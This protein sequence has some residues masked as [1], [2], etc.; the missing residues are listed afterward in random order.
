[1]MYI[2]GLFIL[3][4]SVLT[5]ID[6]ASK[7]AD[8]KLRVG[9]LV[10]DDVYLLDF[11]GPLEVFFDTELEDGSKGFEVFLVAPENKNIRAHTGTLIS[12]DYNIDNCPPID[13]LVVPGGNLNL[14]NQNPKVSDFILKTEKQCQILMS[15]CTGAFIL[16]DLGILNGK[17]ATTWY[18]AK[19]NLQKKYPEIRISD[20]RFTDNGKIITTAGISAGIDGSLY[21]VGRIFGEAIMKK[22]AKYLEWELKDSTN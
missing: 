19:Q 7:P 1:M 9:I 22:T 3:A 13:I 12:P 20:S 6:A 11:T 16:A 5:T 4:F 21:V 14:S 8:K 15:V 10:Y 18:G 2:L 17:E